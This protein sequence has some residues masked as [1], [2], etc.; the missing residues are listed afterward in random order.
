[1]I[2][3]ANKSTDDRLLFHLSDIH[4]GLVDER[5]I[6]WVAAEIERCRPDAVAITGDL[7]MRARAREFAALSC[8]TLSC[9]MGSASTGLGPP[10]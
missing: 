6:A 10:R 4:F 5:A 9:D 8:A 2:E 1:M 7:T 3:P